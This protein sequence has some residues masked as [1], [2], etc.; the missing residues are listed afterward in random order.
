MLH[1]FIVAFNFEKR[2]FFMILIYQVSI[3][4]SLFVK[5]FDLYLHCITFKVRNEFN[6]VV[7]IYFMLLYY[8]YYNYYDYGSER[9]EPGVISKVG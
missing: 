9:F 7:F 1:F 4:K 3:F 5:Y 8:C 2:M 6:L